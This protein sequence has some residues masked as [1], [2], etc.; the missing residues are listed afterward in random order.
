MKK[1]IYI[2]YCITKNNVYISNFSKSIDEHF[3]YVSIGIYNA[4]LD[5]NGIPKFNLVVH[6]LVKFYPGVNY[7]KKVLKFNHW[8]LVYS[9]V[10]RMYG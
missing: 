9:V 4:K 10:Y 3:T 2:H 7:C 6:I 8:L 5:D 1:N